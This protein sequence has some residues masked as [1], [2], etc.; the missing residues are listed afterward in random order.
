MA[1]LLIDENFNNFE[2][3]SNEEIDVQANDI[4]EYKGY[5]L[6]NNIDDEEEGKF[7]EY[8]AHFPYLYLYQKLEILA[9][10]RKEEEEN[11][12]EKKEKKNY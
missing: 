10:S 11:L 6:E 8:G 4:Y 5:F 9:Q 3:E 12:K 1:K 2:E 7:Y